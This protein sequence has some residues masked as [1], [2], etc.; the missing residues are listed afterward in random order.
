MVYFA[1]VTQIG[2]ATNIQK[3]IKIVIYEDSN[4]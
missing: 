3:K 2:N 1:A 4:N